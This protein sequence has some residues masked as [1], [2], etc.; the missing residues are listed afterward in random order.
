MKKVKKT[1]NQGKLGYILINNIKIKI[2]KK[3]ISSLIMI[4]AFSVPA[5][6]LNTNAS[7]KQGIEAYKESNYIGCLQK[8]AEVLSDDPSNTLAHYY[9]GMSNIQLGNGSKGKEAYKKVVL[10]NTNEHLTKLAQKGLTGVII[11]DYKAEEVEKDAEKPVGLAED[12]GKKEVEKLKELKKYEED[13]YDLENGFAY[14][15]KKSNS[16]VSIEPRTKLDDKVDVAKSRLELKGTEKTIQ[17]IE[18]GYLYYDE[19]AKALKR[20]DSIYK[21]DAELKVLE[22]KVN[23]ADLKLKALEKD[24]Q[25]ENASG[26]EVTK[27]KTATERQVEYLYKKD[28]GHFA[29]QKNQN[30]IRK[31]DLDNLKN[32]F[33]EDSDRNLESTSNDTDKKKMN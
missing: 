2:N 33:N 4:S 12:K 6:A 16:V 28:G 13:L 20:S 21:K 27:P 10:L 29:T 9:I 1:Y 32:D 19:N 8:M 3:L 7:L 5:F 14:Y 30:I 25:N 22:G 31:I 23:T 24:L 15:D 17:D 18:N 26:T 11:E